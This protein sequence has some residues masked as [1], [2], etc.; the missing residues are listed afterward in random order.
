MTAQ[1]F[2][3]MVKNRDLVFHVMK[4]QPAAIT[5]EYL[6]Y[7]KDHVQTG[8]VQKG[9]KTEHVY[10]D[11]STGEQLLEH[12][13]TDEAAENFRKKMGK[14]EAE[15]QANKPDNIV[16]R[17]S[18]IFV[19]GVLQKVMQHLIDGGKEGALETIRKEALASEFALQAADFEMLFKG[20]T[21]IYNQIMET[22][23][24]I[25]PK[26]KVH[27]LVEQVVVDPQQSIGGTMDIVALF[28]DNT[29][30]LYD[31]KTLG[32]KADDFIGQGSETKLIKDIVPHY[33][34]EAYTLQLTEYQRILKERYGVKSIRESRIIPIFLR[35]V[36][37]DKANRTEGSWFSNKVALIQMGSEVSPFLEQIAINESTGMRGLDD[38]VLAQMNVLESLRAKVDTVAYSEREAIYKRISAI[39]KNLNHILIKRDFKELILDTIQLARTLNERIQQPRYLEDDK[40]VMRRNPEAL[41][42]SEVVDYYHQFEFYST[43]AKSLAE[44]IESMKKEDVKRYEDIRP[45]LSFVLGQAQMTQAHLQELIVQEPGRTDALFRYAVRW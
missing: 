15:R 4:D 19:H 34:H 2:R 28:S 6:Q 13:V 33:K 43:L 14:A 24:K 9:S 8:E 10:V 40:K 35:S 44:E 31:Y 20:A 32:A 26:G 37:K 38:L 42:I 3:D 23:K 7:T 12:R 11:K 18:G 22:Q 39:T 5:L 29:A 36:I 30:S 27:I 1:E 16:K 25:D 17:D 41:S 45:N 21:K